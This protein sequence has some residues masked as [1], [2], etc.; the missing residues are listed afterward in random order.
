VAPGAA[1]P[2][3]AVVR[4]SAEL[5]AAIADLA[6]DPALGD[7]DLLVVYL[8]GLDIAQHA[9]LSGTDSGGLPP[10]ELSARIA[11]IE[12]YYRFLDTILA[13]LVSPPAPDRL[14]VL[15]TQPGRVKTSSPGLL[16]MSG[17]LARATEITAPA[18]SVA[19]T[20]LHALGV[21]IATDLASPPLESMFSPRY[22]GKYPVR[23]IAT[24]GTRTPMPRGSGA[25][26]LDAEMVERLRSLGYVR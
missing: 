2:V 9:L 3:A 24:Y 6:V 21:P 18:T 11:S 10:S 19:P 14:T 5:D 1:D 8:P 15:V 20:L 7:L 22:L 16:A 25:H 26:A 13:P 17:S 23:S 4:R 12:R